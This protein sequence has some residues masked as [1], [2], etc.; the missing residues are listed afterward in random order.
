MVF[1]WYLKVVNMKLTSQT[2]T[3]FINQSAALLRFLL[4]YC[5]RRQLKNIYIHHEQN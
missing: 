4:P 5:H 3:L 2:L 1:R